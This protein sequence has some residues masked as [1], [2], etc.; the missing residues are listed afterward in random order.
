MGGKVFEGTTS[1][2][3]MNCRHT[4]DKIDQ[5]I[6]EPLKLGRN[7]WTTLGS[8]CKRAICGDMDFGINSKKVSQD[9]VLDQVKKVSEEF[10][11]LKGSNIISFPMPIINSDSQQ[12]GKRVQVDL[13]LTDDLEFSNWMFYSPSEQQSPYKGLY[14]NSLLSAI[15]HYSERHVIKWNK[16]EGDLT[17][18]RYILNFNTGLRRVL[19]SA[20][21]KDG[22]LLKK[23]EI[24]NQAKPTKDL[25]LI[26]RILFGIDFDKE[27]VLTFEEAWTIFMSPVFRHKKHR[28]K[29]VDKM[30]E[31]LNRKGVEYPFQVL[32]FINGY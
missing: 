32:E 6:F 12:F 16:I 17:W 1:I 27:K 13:M 22:K 28:K 18:L 10:K 20:V 7:D 2:Y 9:Q 21:I 29:I 15:S 26:H 25:E 4:V 19:E 5:L 14:R 3:Q 23:K 31:D 11:I 24:I 8:T 30:I